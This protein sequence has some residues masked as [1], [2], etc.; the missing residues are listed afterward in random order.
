MEA[1][2]PRLVLT[3]P[4]LLT[5]PNQTLLAGA[6]LEIP[7]NATSPSGFS[8]TYSVSSTNGA[9]NTT[10]QNG[11]PDI[12][13]NV[14]HTSSGQA[15]DFSFSGTIVIELFPTAAPEHGGPNRESRQRGHLQRQGFLP[16]RARL[17]RPGR[18]GRRFAPG[19]RH[20]QDIG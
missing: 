4:T 8:M 13:L 5:I 19:G 10:L 2:E 7:I 15:G 17:R 18:L 20:G 9:I 12:V 16:D 3:A 14:T 6:P 1:L 11:N